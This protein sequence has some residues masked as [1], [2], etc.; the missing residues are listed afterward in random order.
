MPRLSRHFGAQ[1]YKTMGA[2]RH[3]PPIVLLIAG[4]HIHTSLQPFI[5]KLIVHHA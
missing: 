2:F 1:F 4:G 3:K 5:T